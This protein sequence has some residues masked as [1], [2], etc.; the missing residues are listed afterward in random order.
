MFSLVCTSACCGLANK[1]CRTRL[2]YA[3]RVFQR[4]RVSNGTMQEG[5][6]LQGFSQSHMVLTSNRVCRFA[7]A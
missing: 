2:V 4:A 6:A 1:R 7:G 5:S 3:E